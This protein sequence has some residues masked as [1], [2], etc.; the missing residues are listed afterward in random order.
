VVD[1]AAAGLLKLAD[2]YRETWLHKPPWQ[3]I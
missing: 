1:E 3:G 2:Y